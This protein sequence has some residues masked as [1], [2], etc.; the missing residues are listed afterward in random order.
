MTA[1]RRRK[2]D[3][4]PIPGALFDK[5]DTFASA[6]DRGRVWDVSNQ[7]YCGYCNC[8]ETNPAVEFGAE[9]SQLRGTFAT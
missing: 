4:A 6:A 9:G 3:P 7:T 8:E 5:Q 1:V 2:I